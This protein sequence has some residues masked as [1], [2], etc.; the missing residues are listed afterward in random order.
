MLEY[1]YRY[2]LELWKINVRNS[3]LVLMYF[4]IYINSDVRNQM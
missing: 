4:F 1:F 3:L 2:T